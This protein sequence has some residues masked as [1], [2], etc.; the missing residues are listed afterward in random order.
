MESVFS[1]FTV[2]P[3]FP[4]ERDEN[5]CEA[6]GSSARVSLVANFHFTREAHPAQPKAIPLCPPFIA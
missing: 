6:P 3:P 5:P 1:P 4:S 2:E